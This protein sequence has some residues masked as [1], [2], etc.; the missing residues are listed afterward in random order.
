LALVKGLVEMHRGTVTAQSDGQGQ[1]SAFTVR[2]PLLDGESAATA[3]DMPEEPPTQPGSKRRI[4]VVD[5]NRD[6]AVS[7]ARMLKLMANDVHTAHSG[8]E[9]LSAAESF[10][11]ELILMDVGMPDVDGYDTTRRIREQ[12][13][14]KHIAVYALTGWGQEA[15]RLKSQEAG[16]NGHLVK[17][18]NLR[19][20]ERVLSDLPSRSSP[21]RAL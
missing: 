5:D 14:G 16:C 1:G 18:V 12:P 11:P 2:L 15:D 6:A 4:L 8:R 13:W 21:E 10:R 20:L 19:D 7:M 9:A 17:P 3:D